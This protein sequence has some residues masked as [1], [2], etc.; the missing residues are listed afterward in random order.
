M[1]F[2]GLVLVHDLCVLV[3]RFGLVVCVCWVVC[4]WDWL[5]SLLIAVWFLSYVV[6]FRF[7]WF[8]C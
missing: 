2:V 8:A 7:D 3:F 6:C 1:V 4:W 5:V